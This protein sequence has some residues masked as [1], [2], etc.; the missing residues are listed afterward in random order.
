MTTRL[1]GPFN[2]VEGDLEVRL[3]VEDGRISAA[4][5]NSTLYRGFEPMLAGK[6][7]ADALVIVPRICGICS[8][9]QS[10]AAAAALRELSGLTLSDNGRLALNL[11]SAC[12]NLADHL[13]HFYLFFMPDFAR[14]AYATRPWF[15]RVAQRFKATSGTATADVLPARAAFMHLMGIMAGKW[16]HTLSLQPGG[17]AK[18]L[19]QAECLQLTTL[20]RA[21]RRFLELHVFDDSLESVAG[22]AS[23]PDLTEWRK[24]RHGD[25]AIFLEVAEDLGL[26]KAGRATDVFLSYGAYEEDDGHLFASGLWQGGQAHPLEPGAIVE[27]LSHAWLAGDA[28]TPAQGQTLPL[29]DKPGAYTWCKAPRYS[30]CV[31]ETGALARQMVA[32]HPVIREL[33]RTHGGSVTARVLARLLELALVLPRMEAWARQ[34]EPKAPWCHHA[35]LPDEGTAK[36]LVEAARGALGHWLV[37][38]HGRIANY[39]I[40]AP[41][42]WNFSPRDH[43]GTPGALEQA[44]AGLPAPETE[45]PPLLVQHVVRSFDP[46]MVCTVH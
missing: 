44:L 14:D 34:L 24:N 36:G 33:V 7:P 21:F 4:Y 23:L 28:R 40:I 6:A 13:S 29:P 27:D 10:T 43:Q 46:C 45:D 20:L 3:E 32:G 15:E 37:V 30:G 2:R 26:E 22:L 9:A 17:T 16:P 12:E 39:Q 8:V 38:K 11:V 5:V 18:P 25:L 19:E 35:R 42:T 41:T 31:A 1:I